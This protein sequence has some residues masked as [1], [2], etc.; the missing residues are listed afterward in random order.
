LALNDLADAWSIVQSNS[1]DFDYVGELVTREL[2]STRQGAV[3]EPM[4]AAIVEAVKQLQR[5]LEG[6]PFRNE[7][8]AFVSEELETGLSDTA[9]SR[10][11]KK[12]GWANKIPKRNQKSTKVAQKLNVK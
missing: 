2:K 6:V 9:L 8:C 7:I 1:H 11:L 4:I 3:R 5:D 12:L 10:Q